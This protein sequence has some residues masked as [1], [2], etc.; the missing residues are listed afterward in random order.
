MLSRLLDYERQARKP[1]AYAANE[2]AVDSPSTPVEL[3]EEAPKAPP[4]YVEAPPKGPLD[5][6]AISNWLKTCEDDFERGRDKHAYTKLSDMFKGNGCTRIDN[7]TRMSPELIKTLATQA[8]IDVTLGLVHRVFEYAATDVL[9][10][11][12][13]GKLV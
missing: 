13:S 2:Q 10:V 1:R 8:G 3:V 12:K 11:R 9:R 7:I 4:P 6:P 5:Y